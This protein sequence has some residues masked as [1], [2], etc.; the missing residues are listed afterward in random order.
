[1]KKLFTLLLAVAGLGSLWAQT[2][3]EHFNIDKGW[4]FA[5]GHATDFTKDYNYG[6]NYFSH[7]AKTGYGEGITTAAFDDRSWRLLNLP[8]DWAVEQPFDQKGSLSHGFKAIGRNFPEA[9]IGWYRKVINIP[10]SDFGRRISL[11]FDGVYRNSEVWVNGHYMGNEPSGYLGFEYDITDYVNYGGDNQIVVR[12]D[13]TFEEG[14]FYEGAGIYRHVWLNKT[15]KLHVATDGTFVTSEVKDGQ[16]ELSI[17][18]AVQNDGLQRRNFTMKHILTDAQG[19]E[20]ATDNL[21]ELYVLPYKTQEVVSQLTLDKPVLWDLD[22]PHLYTLTTTVYDNGKAID[23]YTTTIGIRTIRFDNNEGFFLNGKHVK[24]KGTNNHQDHAGVGS[25]MPDGLQE[26]RIKVLK[27]FGSNAYRCS[28]NPPTP[29]LLDVC[30]RLGILVIDEH[31]MM[32]SSLLQKDDLKRLIDRDRNHPS[33]IS[34][35]VGNEEWGIENKVSGARI[36]QTMQGYVKSLDSTRPAT[37]AFSGSIGSKGITTTLDLLGINYIVNKSTDDQHKL[38]PAQSIWGTEEGSTHA[39]RGVY[40]R[41]DEKHHIPAYDKAPNSSFISIED[42]WKH[43]ASRDYLGGMFIWT[44]FD[45]RGEPTPYAW[46]SIGTYF[47]M[48]DQC[49]FYKDDAWYLKSWWGNEPVLHLLPHWNWEGKEGQPIEVWAHSNCDEVELFLN[50][51]SLG[52]KKMEANSHL[53]WM[54]NYT[55]GTLEAV[56]YKNGKKVLTDRIQ[57]TK[58]PATLALTGNASTIKANDTDIVMVTVAV[59]DKNGLAVPTAEDEVGFSIK[60]P[61]RIIGV[62]NGNPSSLERDRFIETIETA[63]IENLKEKIVTATTGNEALVTESYDATGWDNA[64]KDDRTQEFGQKAPALVYRGS[65]TLPQWQKDAT[66]TLFSSNIG[67]EQSVYV[68]GKLV[69][70]NLKQKAELVLPHDILHTGANS[71]AIVA[72]PILK[73]RPW[74]FINMN[75]GLVRI[76]TPAPQWKRKLFSGLAQVIIQSTGEAGSIELTATGNG[77]KPATLTVKA[78]K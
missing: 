54:V 45:Y 31:R 46:P 12:A 9:S 40:F 70:A 77:L 28:H 3:R 74:D 37:A 63:P 72:T 38:F 21:L 13:A 73:N 59:K 14:W 52:K 36:A 58:A 10:E 15:D 27:S 8:H 20:V 16:A 26:Y 60:G 4:R 11:A 19:K 22:N 69:A 50:K 18:V 62:G 48:V 49:G 5:F 25:A 66:I 30:D 61:G 53:Q 67:V 65:F 55:P 32:G 7:L 78:Q 64:F 76:F 57:T 33:V 41:D 34:W 35:S 43:Y 29:E 56:G 23:T 44:G 75:P 1:M 42:G 17:S 68:N 24:I 47:G 2:T 51:K 39:T 71:I 6:T